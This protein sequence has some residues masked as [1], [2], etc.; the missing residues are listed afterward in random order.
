TGWL[1][2]T[3]RF[4]SRELLRARS[5]R[6]TREQESYMQST[7]NDSDSETVW[8]QLAPLLEDAMARLSEKD[9]ALVAL[10][11]FENK[12]IAETSSL[13]GI[14]EWA[15]RKRLERAIERLRASFAE[16]GV[17]VPAL[18]L[19]T[20]ITANAV[21]A[22]PVAL[23]KSVATVAAAKGFAASGSTLTL[24]KGALKV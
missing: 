12:S 23:A 21:K 13:L 1:Y 7:L 17:V 20:A 10:R 2:E 11:F 14:Q 18:A 5:R 9:R 24:I 22:A 6:Q 19:T 15:A 8:Q 3:T 16:R 4:T